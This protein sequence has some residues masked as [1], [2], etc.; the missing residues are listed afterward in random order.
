MQIRLASVMVDNQD[1]ALRFYTTVL[2]FV[3][4]YDM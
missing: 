3:K 1:N 4:K 2:G